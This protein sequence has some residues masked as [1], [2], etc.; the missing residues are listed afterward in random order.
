MK[1]SA[2]VFLAAICLTAGCDYTRPAT[3]SGTTAEVTEPRDTRE[4]PVEDTT[5]APD[6]RTSDDASPAD[7][8][9]ASDS[10]D[11]V[12]SPADT[13]PIGLDV[14]VDPGVHVN[15][16]PEPPPVV[17][18]V[19]PTRPHRRMD[20]D[21]LDASLRRA[22]G[23]L[24]WTRVTNGVEENLF[25]TLASTLGKPDFINTTQEDLA[26]SALFQKFLGEAARSIC[27]RLADEESRDLRAP[28]LFAKVTPT[29]TWDAAPTKVDANLVSLLR[30]FHASDLTPDA[31]G[32]DRWRWLFRSALH[33]SGD[34]VV[35]WRA[36]CI[37]LITHPD[38]WTY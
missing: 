24:G 34:P 14:A 35:A 10:G 29:D 19:D 33:T 2:H 5:A 13:G 18:P 1:R 20:I 22:T 27:R 36:V 3:V 9:T 21:Q 6:A 28:I 37:G 7:A 23:G 38:F 26:P 30:R 15:L 8:Q 12:A 25:T 4:P 32:F 17:I 11:D 16:L 31:P